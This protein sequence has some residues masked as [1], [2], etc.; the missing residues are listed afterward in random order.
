MAAQ[1]ES[2][3]VPS[4]RHVNHPPLM[5]ADY[6]A[7]AVRS[8]TMKRCSISTAGL[9]V[10]ACA[11]A[12]CDAPDDKGTAPPA[13]GGLGLRLTLPAR[14][15]IA[16]VEYT[17]TG[18]GAFTRRDAIPVDSGVMPATF[19]ARID[20]IPAARGYR[21]AL[22]ASNDAD[23]RCSGSAN[24]DVVADAMTAVTVRLQCH[25]SARSHATGSVSV[26]GTIE[27]CAGIDA[28]SASASDD[29]SQV[30]RACAR[31]DHGNAVSLH[32][33]WS[34]SSG[35][36]SDAQDDSVNLHCPP[37]GGDVTVTASVGDSVC[38]TSLALD[39]T[40]RAQPQQATPLYGVTLDSVDDL[41]TVLI[42][43]KNLARRPTARV[44]FDRD[45]AAS[46]YASPVRNI[47]DVAGVMGEVLDSNSVS[48]VTVDAYAARAED[49]LN[50]LGDDVDIWEIGNEVNGEWLGSSDDVAQKIS[51]AYR[52]VHERGKPTALTLFYNPN[53][54]DKP[55]HE[56]FG[57]TD[58]HV[59][60]DL[61]QHLDY[62]LLSYYEDSCN[63][64]Q[65]DWNMVFARVARIFPNSKLG[66]GECGT[67]DASRKAQDI[68]NYYDLRV[69]LPQYIGGYFW[70]YYRQDMLPYTSQLWSVLN[71]SLERAP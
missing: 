41:P 1:I 53:C 29:G 10:F 5:A 31:D 43:L 13:L 24:F 47:H 62:V 39:V 15:D 67:T 30:I 54:W 25:A 44:V 19:D 32:Y 34:S 36:L 4:Q 37:A 27:L 3:I 20:A 57:W 6:E 58:Q 35:R 60:D 63:G 12:A 61:K 18:P 28:V 26:H 38:A 9:C 59:P 70:W 2:R 48:A 50:T 45:M 49:F 69:N 17:I 40:C 65:P 14:A 52:I 42:S 68:R 71:M 55:D 23:L 7:A 46:D 66:F 33:T 11:L 22:D 56:M 51:A 21:L 8:Q 16:N 64:Q